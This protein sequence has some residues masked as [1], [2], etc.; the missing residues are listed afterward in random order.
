MISFGGVHAIQTKRYR[1]ISILLL[2]SIFIVFY[3]LEFC[4]MTESFFRYAYYWCCFVFFYVCVEVYIK[5]NVFFSHNCGVSICE[6]RKINRTGTKRKEGQKKPNWEKQRNRKK[7]AHNGNFII[8]S[9]HYFVYI[10]FLQLENDSFG[11]V[12]LILFYFAAFHRAYK[13]R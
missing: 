10:Y 13:K 12:S 1:N 3:S 6:R 4:R 5:R 2:F 9:G 11:Q 7:G 8:I